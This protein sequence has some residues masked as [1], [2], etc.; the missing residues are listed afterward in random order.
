[1]SHLLIV[2][3][4]M[5]ISNLAAFPPKIQAR[6]WLASDSDTARWGRSACFRGFSGVVRFFTRALVN[7]CCSRNLEI[8]I[9]LLCSCVN[10][11]L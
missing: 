3:L 11:P 1:M 7:V 10:L 8:E 9:I 5:F 2:K 4:S 6:H